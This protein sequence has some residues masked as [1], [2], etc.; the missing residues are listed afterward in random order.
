MEIWRNGVMRQKPNHS[1]NSKY[2]YH[3]IICQKLFRE[4]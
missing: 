1:S 3:S 2:S 4:T